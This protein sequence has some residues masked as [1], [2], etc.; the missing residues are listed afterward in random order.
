MTI[1]II[2]T[3]MT[4]SL[5]REGCDQPYFFHMFSADSYVCLSE[6]KLPFSSYRITR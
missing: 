3:K 6:S 5:E 1:S 4:T 2:L